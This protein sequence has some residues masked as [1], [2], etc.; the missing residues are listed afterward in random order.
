MQCYQISNHQVSRLVRLSQDYL[1]NRNSRSKELLFDALSVTTKNLDPFDWMSWE[2]GIN[3]LNYY[4]SPDHIEPTVGEKDGLMREIEEFP[5]SELFR[6]LIVVLRMDRFVDGAFDE[7]AS[8]G[9]IHAIA[10]RIL[11]LR[12]YEES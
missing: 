7:Y 3:A 1:V 11:V 8:S 2:V 10:E 4:E 9:V 6:L 12:T 5:E